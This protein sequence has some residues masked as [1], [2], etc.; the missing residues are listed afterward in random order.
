MVFPVS[1]SLMVNMCKH[2]V[3]LSIAV[4]ALPVNPNPELRSATLTFV[5][6]NS[7]TYGI[8]CK[9]VVDAL[10]KENKKAGEGTYSFYT[11]A[12]GTYWVD[13][14]FSAAPPLDFIEVAPDLVIREIHPDMPKAIGKKPFVIDD[15]EDICLGSLQHGIAVGFPEEK[16][17]YH[18]DNIGTR[19]AES[20][21]YVIAEL[22]SKPG[23]QF[24]LF[25]ELPDVPNISS[26]SGMSGGPVYWSTLEKYGLLGICYEAKHTDPNRPEIQIGVERI[27]KERFAAWIGI[28]GDKVHVF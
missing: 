9:H 2:C 20:C 24:W 12:N 21:I 18:K 8:T 25:S 26:Y 1:D 6:F 16:K 7:R 3:T 23:T 4:N 28:L 5:Q 11:F 10:N 13:N 22:H 17:F 19:V 15:A 27:T 14:K